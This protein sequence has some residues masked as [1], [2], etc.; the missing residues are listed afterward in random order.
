MSGF[1]IGVIV[2]GLNLSWTAAF[3][4]ISH[5]IMFTGYGA[6]N[7]RYPDSGISVAENTT[8]LTEANRRATSAV[9]AQ[10]DGGV[11]KILSTVEAVLGLK[12]VFI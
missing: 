6:I 9:T 5:T 8:R 2:G 7:K 12:L 11:Q 4:R 10:F 3:L 1:R